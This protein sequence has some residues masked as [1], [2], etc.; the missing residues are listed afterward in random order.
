MLQENNSSLGYYHHMEFRPYFLV[1]DIV[2]N[3]AVGALACVLACWVTAS[4]WPMALGMLVGMGIGMFVGL[5][6]SLLVFTPLL[7]AM[8]VMVPCMLVGMLAGMAG[9]MWPLSPAEAAI[10]GAAIGFGVIVF[11]GILNAFLKGPQN[12]AE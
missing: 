2:A 1:G 7:G 10:W 12:M 3:C 6:A 5:M 11:V 8:E 9:G 4:G